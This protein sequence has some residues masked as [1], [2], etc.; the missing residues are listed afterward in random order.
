MTTRENCARAIEFRS[1][2]HLPVAIRCNVGWLHD[3]DENGLA[4][5][6]ELEAAVSRDVLPPDLD[7]WMHGPRWTDS[8]GVSRFTDEWGALWVDTDNGEITEWYPMEEGYD[9]VDAVNFPDPYRPGRFDVADACLKERRDIYIAAT[10]WLT[11][12]ERLWK[13]RGFSNMLIDPYVD[14]ENFARLRDRVVEVNLGMID[15]WIK[16]DIDAVYFSDD[17][18]SQRALLMDPD[19]WRKFYK[20]SYTAMFDRVRAGGKHVWM[21]SCGDITQILPDLIEIGLNVLNPVQPQAMDVHYLSREFGGKICFH[22][23]LDVQGT[24]IRGTPEDVKRDVDTLVDLFARFDGG[25]IGGTSHTIMPETPLRNIIAMYEAF[26]RY[27]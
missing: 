15:Q 10:V 23:G 18:G 24:M 8:H 25:Y 4:R 26:A 14:E 7:C 9:R 5:I 19:D 13:L 2:E 20:P 1:P 22:G 17:W 12:F 6:G 11:L 27:I 21:H 3:R 16:R